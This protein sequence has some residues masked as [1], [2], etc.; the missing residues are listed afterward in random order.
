MNTRSLSFLILASLFLLGSCSPDN[1]TNTNT[2]PHSEVEAVRPNN[3]EIELIDVNEREVGAQNVIAFRFNTPIDANQ[4]LSERIQ[5][6]PEADYFVVSPNAQSVYVYGIEPATEYRYTVANIEAQNSSTLNEPSSGELV[7]RNLQAY[8]QFDVGGAILNLNSVDRINIRSLN[9]EAADLNLY[10]IKDD[11]LHQFFANPQ[12]FSNER[13]GYFTNSRRADTLEHLTTTRIELSDIEN[14]RFETAVTVEELGDLSK[15]G[16]YFLTASRPG[17]FDFDAAT[18]ISVSDIGLQLRRYNEELVVIA[19]SIETGEALQ[20]VRIERV[21]NQGKLVTYTTTNADGLARFH[22]NQLRGDIF[23]AT[24]NDQTS[25]IRLWQRAY[26]LSEYLEYA[27]AFEKEVHAI[28]TPRNLYRAGDTA[29]FTIFVKDHDGNPSQLAQTISIRDAQGQTVY[30]ARTVP[31]EFGVIE[32]EYPISGS[33]PRGYWAVRVVGF[34]S[35][36]QLRFQVEDFVP[37]TMELSF[38]H[39]RLDVLQLTQSKAIEL[40]IAGHYLY[41]APADGNTLSIEVET[42]PIHRPLTQHSAYFFGSR[43]GIS[44]SYAFDDIEL[45]TS[46]EATL[47]LSQAMLSGDLNEP[48]EGIQVPSRITWWATL[49]ESGGRALE[50]Q[51]NSIWWPY[52]YFVGIKP[53]EE[54]VKENSVASFSL[55]RSASDGSLESQGRIN[56]LVERTE[57]NSY[58]TYTDQRGW[59]FERESRSYP[60]W[61]EQISLVSNEAQ[62]EVPVEWGDYTVTLTDELG[63]ITTYRFRAGSNWYNRVMNAEQE[64]NPERASI[65]MHGDFVH[66]GGTVNATVT[67]PIQGHGIW[68]VET[69]RILESGTFELNGETSDIR[70]TIPEALDRHDAYVTVFVVSRE[71]ESETIRQRA[72]GIEPL[73]LDRRQEQLQLSFDIESPWQPQSTQRVLV[74]VEDGLGQPVSGEVMLQLAAVDLGAINVSNYAPANLWESFYGQRGLGLSGVSDIY[75]YVLEPSD[76]ESARIRWGGDI[77]YD[78]VSVTASRVRERGAQAPEPSHKIIALQSETVTVVN[79]QA[80]VQLDIPYFNGALKLFGLAYGTRAVGTQ[81]HEVEVA[82]PMI[83]QLNTPRFLADG[84]EATA[85]L[86][87]RNQTGSNQVVRITLNTLGAL[88]ETQII[89]ELTLAD[90]ERNQVQVP[91]FAEM[92]GT[93]GLI[94]LKL[95]YGNDTIERSWQIGTRPAEV[96][97]YGQQFVAVAEGADAS[98]NLAWFNALDQDSIELSVRAMN[99]PDFGL[100]DHIQYLNRYEYACLEQTLSKLTPWVYA[101]DNQLARALG[102]EHIAHRSTRINE[103]LDR[104]VQLQSSSGAFRLWPEARND[105]P[106]L[107]VY[108]A[109]ILLSMRDKGIT[110]NSLDLDSLIA[111]LQMY[112]LKPQRSAAEGR[113][114]DNPRAL[115]ASYKAYAAYILAREGQINL[116]P[117]RDLY[118]AYSGIAVSS[119]PYAHFSQAFDL[120]GASDEAE[121]AAKLAEVQQRPRDFWL[122]DYGS[123]LRDQAMQ[124]ALFYNGDAYDEL[125][126]TLNETPWLNTQ[127]RAQLLRLGVSLNRPTSEL[128]FVFAPNSGTAFDNSAVDQTIDLNTRL[129]NQGSERAFLQFIW[130]GT[131]TTAP[132]R[133]DEIDVNTAWFVVRDDALVPL[134]Q[135]MDVHV[136]EYVIAST[137]SVA[138]TRVSDAML[139]HL[140]PA[141][142]ELINPEL[143]ELRGLES[144]TPPDGARFEHYYSDHEAYRDDRYIAVF[145]LYPNR[146]AQFSYVMRATTEGTFVVPSTLVE[147]MYRNDKNGRHKALDSIRVI[148][149]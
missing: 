13:Q 133:Q 73:V 95:E 93:S 110:V 10:R 111:Q 132:S 17:S 81:T 33:A 139:I 51:Y 65:V 78:E 108:A 68:T 147:S 144:I 112:V 15:S 137:Q 82:A 100:D 87:V 141:G 67:S 109:D 134:T 102:E 26:E 29:N 36:D 103:G 71:G 22:R 21:D 128:N 66:P 47:T 35:S 148:P 74:Q 24:L 76:R 122:G 124:L 54:D 143:D 30:E 11:K 146:A 37:E 5:I 80:E 145:D 130:T 106:W 34:H 75:G 40:P 70:I 113:H 92:V 50:R 69:D 2:Q 127:E 89:K 79:G 84:D 12:L 120:L 18:W 38:N 46:G 77:M 61:Q 31:N 125:L 41:G 20:G 135:G 25:V 64:A 56:V 114:S 14:Y 43:S 53:L 72:F 19:Q 129:V 94:E 98:A 62:L 86:D 104:L 27:P 136:G 101:S 49:F 45:D 8:V 116:G 88:R 58:W 91:L 96:A 83:T 121:T 118:Q 3:L 117:V 9:T 32:L 52:P 97:V 142:L 90:S 85:V 4:V 60:V 16:V 42:T 131:P 123:P 39:D 63:G 28:Y 105:D 57:H 48:T 44:K 138:P 126:R 55:I 99:T 7:T 107:T 149:R 1:T 115:D 140:I 6:E 23:V 59:F 119:L